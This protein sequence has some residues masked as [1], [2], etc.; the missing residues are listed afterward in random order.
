MAQ[1]AAQTVTANKTFEATR[2]APAALKPALAVN[3]R[4]ATVSLSVQPPPVASSDTASLQANQNA[5]INVLA[6]D[7]SDGGTLDTA[8]VIITAPPA[9]GT[10]VVSN[11]GVLYT[12]TAGYS[13]SDTF[14]YSVRDNLGAPSNVATV[15]IDVAA[16]PST[17]GG[18]GSGSTAGSGGGGGAMHVLD[19]AALAVF[20]LLMHSLPSRWRRRRI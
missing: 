9:H 7:K 16:P 18:G 6:N 14:Q 13:G 3:K 12:A 15:S 2:N 1:E 20:L 4:V 11:G 10:A 5:A 17:G 19:V 8:S